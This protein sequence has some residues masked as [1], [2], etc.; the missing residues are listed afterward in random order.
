VFGVSLP[1][2]ETVFGASLPLVESISL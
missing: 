1:L 2:V